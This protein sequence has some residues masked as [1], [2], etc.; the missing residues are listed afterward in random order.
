[1]DIRRFSLRYPFGYLQPQHYTMHDSAHSRLIAAVCYCPRLL[2]WKSHGTK[3]TI[4]YAR[5]KGK[6]V[7]VVMIE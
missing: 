3:Y 4:E 7:K 2:G 6:P 1:M 5:Q